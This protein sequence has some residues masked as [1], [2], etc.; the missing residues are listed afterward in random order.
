MPRSG[1]A[2]VLQAA[3]TYRYVSQDTL[4]RARTFAPRGPLVP[5]LY[6]DAPHA[7]SVSDSRSRPERRGPR[8]MFGRIHPSPIPSQAQSQSQSRPSP[9]LQ[10]QLSQRRTN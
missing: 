1:I 8:R 10:P 4:R 3:V 7:M 2:F 5:P 9:N 6:V